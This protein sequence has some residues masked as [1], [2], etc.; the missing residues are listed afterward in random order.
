MVEWNWGSPKAVNQVSV[1]QAQF[2]DGSTSSVEVQLLQPDGDWKVVA[3]A[4]GPVGDGK[5]DVPYLLATFPDGQT[6][7]AMRV[8]M[9]GTGSTS[10]LD[11]QDAHVLG[12]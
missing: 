12:Q 2:A 10:P 6:A 8:V 4:S 3:S 5:G 9:S 7:A 1:G 11:I